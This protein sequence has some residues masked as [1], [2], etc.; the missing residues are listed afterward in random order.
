MPNIQVGTL[1]VVSEHGP[2]NMVGFS[3]MSH[4]RNPDTNKKDPL[5]DDAGEMDSTERKFQ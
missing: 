3:I 2:I 4:T 1:Q 5:G